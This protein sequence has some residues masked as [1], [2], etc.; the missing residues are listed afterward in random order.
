MI[1]TPLPRRAAKALTSS[2]AGC[3]RLDVPSTNTIEAE[4]AL[5]E[6]GIGFCAAG[7]DGGAP[8]AAGRGGAAAGRAGGSAGAAGGVCA[9]GAGAGAAGAG[10]VNGAL[11]TALRGAGAGAGAV[12]DAEG[13]AVTAGMEALAVPVLADALLLDGAGPD[14]GGGG[15]EPIPNKDGE[16]EGE[17]G[18]ANGAA[19]AACWAFVRSATS[20]SVS[21]FMASL[22]GAAGRS[23]TVAKFG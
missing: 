4:A 13:G 20:E 12:A 3:D 11:W 1:I 22:S 15:T 19:C 5:A 14:G 16:A 21:F 23:G 7:C 8:A 17:D 18:S 6:A 2:D 10:T 9:V